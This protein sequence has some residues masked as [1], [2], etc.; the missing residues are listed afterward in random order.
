MSNFSSILLSWVLFNFACLFLGN[1]PFS[2]RRTW[3]V[4][5]WLRIVI[6]V[7]LMIV[8]VSL[9]KLH[10]RLHV[11]TI[12]D[13][14]S[15]H[16]YCVLFHHNHAML[17]PPQRM[18]QPTQNI[19]N[20]IS[21]TRLLLFKHNIVDLITVAQFHPSRAQFGFASSQS[22]TNDLRQHRWW[23]YRCQ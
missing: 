10:L 23:R 5:T 6:D 3:C 17:L 16:R 9:A 13:Q 20:M 18:C 1:S 8:V 21:R 14:F 11:I 4:C 19:M 7:N 2:I 22:V 12:T 15:K